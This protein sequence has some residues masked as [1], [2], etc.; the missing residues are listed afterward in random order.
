MYNLLK[1]TQ[2][3]DREKVYV[4]GGEK[5][6]VEVRNAYSI[7]FLKTQQQTDMAFSFKVM[8]IIT[9]ILFCMKKDN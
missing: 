4:S 3:I 7:I 8:R 2:Q 6:G 1:K 5:I 9:F